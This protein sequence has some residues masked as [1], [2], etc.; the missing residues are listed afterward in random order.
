MA[1]SKLT[2]LAA[3]TTA[4]TDDLLYVV[5]DPGGTPASKKITFDNV[6]K[7]ISQVGG[8]STSLEVYFGDSVTDGTYRMR[9][10]GGN[11]VVEQRQSGSYIEV[12]AFQP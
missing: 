4:S 2:A 5:D 9:V 8:T 3:I 10:S 11:L 7:S 12:G 1:D 6:Q